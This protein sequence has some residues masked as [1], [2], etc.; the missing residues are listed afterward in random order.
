[1]PTGDGRGRVAALEILL[2]DDAIRNLIRE[3]KIE[4]VYSVMQTSTVKGMQTMEQALADLTLRHVITRRERVLADEP[5]RPAPP[6]CS[7]AA[8]CRS[9]SSSPSPAI[10]LPWQVPHELKK[11]IRLSE[12][13]EQAVGG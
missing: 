10:S 7:S 9:W 5:A 8:A 4:Q 3:A 6:A 12:P 13:P 1:M 2:P 11:E